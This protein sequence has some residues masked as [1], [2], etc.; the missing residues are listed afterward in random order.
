MILLI[1][2][3][4]VLLSLSAALSVVRVAL[5]PTVFDRAVALD[6]LSGIGISWIACYAARRGDEVLADATIPL[7]ALAAIGTA[8]IGLFIARR[9]NGE[10]RTWK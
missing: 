9:P 6:L 8:A 4:L 3:T 7:A 1:D 2:L 10:Q 5:G